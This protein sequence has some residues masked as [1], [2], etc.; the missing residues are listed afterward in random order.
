MESLSVGRE[1]L[2]RFTVIVN[3]R[4]RSLILPLVVFILLKNKCAEHLLLGKVLQREAKRSEVAQSCPTLC[5]PVDCS[6]L[7]SSIHGILQARIL[8]WV[9]ISF[10]RGSSQPRLNLGLLHYRQ[11]LSHLSHQGSPYITTRIISQKD[12][13][14]MRD[15]LGRELDPLYP[16]FPLYAKETWGLLLL[17]MVIS[18]AG[19]LPVFG[20]EYKSV[21]IVDCRKVIYLGWIGKT[22]P[23]GSSPGAVGGISLS[24]AFSRAVSFPS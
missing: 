8:E 12:C 20:D 9:A 15:P 1:I 10:S 14:A 21:V 5:D 4:C 7:G 22:G 16:V 23:Q 6:L 2:V 13:L 24:L 3:L 11:M 18:T 19:G 17:Q